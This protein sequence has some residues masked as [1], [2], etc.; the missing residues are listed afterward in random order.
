MLLQSKPSQYTVPQSNN[1]LLFTKL[2]VR[3]AVLVIQSRIRWFYLGFVHVSGV[4]PCFFG[5]MTNWEM[6]RFRMASFTCVMT[7]WLST[8]MVGLLSL[9]KLTSWLLTWECKV[10]KREPISTRPL[11]FSLT[12]GITSHFQHSIIKSHHKA[13]INYNF[14]GGI[15][16]THCKKKGCIQG[17]ECSCVYIFNIIQS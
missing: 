15:A 13:S 12:P 2:W 3:W 16:K 10:F 14:M 4:C 1:Y 8:M 17:R 7:D 11:E 5:Q 9:Q 6:A